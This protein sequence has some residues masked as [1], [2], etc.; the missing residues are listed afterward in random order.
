MEIDGY[1]ID[2]NILEDQIANKERKIIYQCIESF[3]SK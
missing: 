3:F 1:Y 2:E